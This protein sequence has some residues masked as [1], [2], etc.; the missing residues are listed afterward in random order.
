MAWTRE[1]QNAYAREWRRK[2]PDAVGNGNLQRYGLD[3]ASYDTL[4]KA[5]GGVCAVCKGPPNGRGKEEGRYHVDHNHVT[6]EVRALLCSTCNTGLGK[7]HDD[8][9]LLEAAAAYIRS[10]R[11]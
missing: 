11:S 3:M 4:L 7:F 1:Q 5:Q 6:G 10:K 9:E 8:P 2:H